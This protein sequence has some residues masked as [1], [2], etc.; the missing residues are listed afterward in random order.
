MTDRDLSPFIHDV[1]EPTSALLNHLDKLE[2]LLEPLIGHPNLEDL[3]SGMSEADQCRVSLLRSSVLTSL[4]HSFCVANCL[5]TKD[6][7]IEREIERLLLYSSKLRDLATQN[8][9]PTIHTVSDARTSSSS[10]SHAVDQFLSSVP[11]T[12][13]GTQV[14]QPGPVRKRSRS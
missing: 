11:T 14:Y 9:P 2:T 6:H 5:P 12:G 10:H 8:H 13:D 4:Y 3:L 7:E 1:E